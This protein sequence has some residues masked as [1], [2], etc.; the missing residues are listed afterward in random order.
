VV[1]QRAALLQFCD[2]HVAEAMTAPLQPHADAAQ[3]VTDVARVPAL[4]RPVGE[5]EHGGL[6]PPVSHF[7]LVHACGSEHATAKPTKTS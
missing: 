7:E 2:P 4:D 5:G 3:E 6:E 1:V